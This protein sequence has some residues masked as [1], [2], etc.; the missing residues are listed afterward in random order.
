[1]PPKRGG[2]RR[3]GYTRSSYKGSGSGRYAKKPMYAATRKKYTGARSSR[4][5]GRKYTGGRAV[6]GTKSI[7]PTT[8]ASSKQRVE[9]KCVYLQPFDDSPKGQSINAYTSSIIKDVADDTAIVEGMAE[10]AFDRFLIPLATLADRADSW[11]VRLATTTDGASYDTVAYLCSRNLTHIPEGYAHT[12]RIGRVVNVLGINLL[13]SGQTLIQNDFAPSD[14][15]AGNEVVNVP[16]RRP[17]IWELIVLQEYQVPTNYAHLSNHHLMETMFDLDGAFDIQSAFIANKNRYTADAHGKILLHK[18]IKLDDKNN[19]ITRKFSIRFKKPLE[20]R[21]RGSGAA[22]VAENR[23]LCYLIPTAA[24]PADGMM[25]RMDSSTPDKMNLA[26]N[27]TP[28]CLNVKETL[29]FTD[30]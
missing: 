16:S 14:D 24:V 17:A 26:W 28:S 6:V 2:Y 13:V 18:R 1:M 11:N 10:Q 21:Y 22:E 4:W 8:V 12:A 25:T 15:T 19:V 30:P 20:V 5:G 27:F 9:V 23:I 3:S 7:V 29:L